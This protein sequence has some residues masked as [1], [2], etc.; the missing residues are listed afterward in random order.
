[1]R[2]AHF[3][4]GKLGRE[5]V[6]SA[7]LAMALDSV[8]R[9][10][11]HFFKL[12][13]PDEY[14]SLSLKEWSVKVEVRQVD[15]RM[16]TDDT[17]VLIENKVNAGAKQDNQLLRYY[18]REKKHNPKARV[19]LVY[20]APGQIGKGEI[21]RVT[22]SCKFQACTDDHLYHLSW[23]TLATYSPQADNIRDMIL[24]NG[25]DEIKRVIEEART[26]KYFREGDR[27]ILY[28]VVKSALNKLMEQTNVRLMGPW[29]GREN[30][31]IYTAGTN[32]TLWLDSLFKAENEP[33]YAPINLR[34]ENDLF[35]ITIRSQFKLAGKVNKDLAKWWG[36]QI[37]AKSME[38]PGVGIHHLQEDGW[39]VH[40]RATS[41][42]KDLI[43]NALV[44]TG[45]AVLGTLSQ[46]LSSAGFELFK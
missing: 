20:L 1:M 46:K 16:E 39:L 40:S 26:Q 6:S 32:V 17:I 19:I 35:R 9:F 33:P 2:L 25:L 15:V 22:D 3:F 18:L 31:Q 27:G 34:D 41:G 4:E 13:A 12:V 37:Q 43:E 14:N 11:E 29:P 44:N 5:E 24:R 10:R 38:I 7:F 8:P 42:S 30:E 28:H 36:Q 23:E 45:V 21:T